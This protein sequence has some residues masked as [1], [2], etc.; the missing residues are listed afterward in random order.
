MPLIRTASLV[1]CVVVL[2]AC[3]TAV[4]GKRAVQSI[5]ADDAV[6]LVTVLSSAPFA[7]RAPETPGGQLAQ[8]TLVSEFRKAGL[9]PVPGRGYRQVFAGGVNIMG[10][11]PGSGDLGDEVIVVGA[12]FDH[13]GVQKGQL[14]AGANDNASGVAA[15]IVAAG[16]WR[17]NPTKPRR[18]VLIVA[19]DAEETDLLGSKHFV[20]LPPV[21]KRRIKAGI[22]LDMVGIRAHQ[23]FGNLLLVLGAEKSPGLTRLADKTKPEPNHNVVLGGLHLLENSPFGEMILSDYAPFRDAEIPFAMLTAGMSPQ[24]HQPSDVAA[25]IHPDLLQANTR[26]LHRFVRQLMTD[27]A[28]LTF[29]AAGNNLLRDLREVSDILEKAIAP[30]TTFVGPH[31][32]RDALRNHLRRLDGIR[33]RLSRGG[34]IEPS[35][36]PALSHSVFRLMCYCGG[37]TSAWAPMC[38]RF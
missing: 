21:S 35:D 11:I 33:R 1:L 22:V 36:A 4:P 27:P 34:T 3:A 7:G 14:Y 29:Q 8:D 10:W 17:N 31:I 24:Y 13:L 28:P 16:E 19:F 38:N 30:D 20:K 32:H 6:R 25:A 15:M 5:S 23:Q 12:H 26:W 2:D 9:E 18:S 37:P